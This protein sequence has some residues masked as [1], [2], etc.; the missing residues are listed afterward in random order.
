MLIFWK[1]VLEE[2]EYIYAKD[3]TKILHKVESDVPYH[4]TK[5]DHALNYIVGTVS[6]FPFLISTFLNPQL[7]LFFHRRPDPNISDKLFKLLSIFDFSTNLFAPLVYTVLML[8][9]NVY[10]SSHPVLFCARVI[11]CTCGCTSQVITFLLAVVRFVKITFPLT[12]IRELLVISYV[13]LYCTYMAINNFIHIIVDRFYRNQPHIIKQVLENCFYSN[14]AH[15]CV[16]V[17]VSGITVI[18]LLYRTRTSAGKGTTSHNKYMKSCVTLL[19]LNG[20]Y[21][22]VVICI[23]NTMWVVHTTISYHEILYAWIPIF[24]STVNPLIIVCRRSNVRKFIFDRVKCFV[25]RT[26]VP[27]EMERYKD[28]SRAQT[29][30]STNGSMRGSRYVMDKMPTKHSL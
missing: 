1:L 13:F 11:C 19:L 4:P 2:D 17:V 8:S 25:L 29:M 3:P 20:Q 14:F 28:E 7:C 18:M 16:G 23:V 26:S 10:P 5:F 30:V 21:I 12:R 6:I 9:P 15:C 24:T 22:L 27:I